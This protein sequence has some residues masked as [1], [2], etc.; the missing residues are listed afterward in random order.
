MSTRAGTSDQADFGMYLGSRVDNHLA[1]I[2]CLTTYIEKKVS[3][4]SIKAFPISCIQ[5]GLLLPDYTSIVIRTERDFV[6]TV[7]VRNYR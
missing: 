6:R 3:D 4:E 1:C 2:N 7:C 5:V